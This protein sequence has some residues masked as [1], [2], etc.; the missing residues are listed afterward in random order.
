[1]QP[2]K[3]LIFIIC[4]G[5]L[6]QTHAQEIKCDGSL[7]DPVINQNFGAG[8][9]PGK[10]LS[11]GMTNMSYTTNNCPNDGEYTIAN[12]LTG[13]GNCHPNTWHNVLSDHTGNPNGYMM[14]VN[15]SL[16]PSIF[17]TQPAGGLCPNT[18]YQFSAYVLNLITLAASR[19]GI[20]QPNITFS[21][22]TTSGKVLKTENEGFPPTSTPQWVQYATY[23]T[24]PADATDVVV[25]MTN[26][27]P[28]GDG[29]DLILDDITF[30]ACGP[31]IQSGI[32]SIT[33]GSNTSICQGTDAVYNL[34]AAIIGDNNPVYQWQSNYNGGAWTDVSGGA[35][36]ALTVNF[37]AAN[38]A[39][40]YQYRLGVANGS[41]ITD[42]ACRVYSTPLTITVNPL[43][44]VPPIPA[45][46]VC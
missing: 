44:V 22:Q 19:P 43:P 45:P 11:G 3:F 27:A 4:A 38:P 12:S 21:I 1:M 46:T 31:I 9:N 36:N 39:G 2:V 40:S 16:L 28:G 33:G 37:S 41:I 13:S 25:T 34:Q 6:L 24:T 8:T 30:R 7:G 29:N 42:A 17:F 26:N 15:A 14:I 20:S 32:S 5:F 18:T 35:N 23:F 10:A